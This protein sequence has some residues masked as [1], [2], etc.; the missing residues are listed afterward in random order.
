MAPDT[1]IT[2][3]ADAW[4]RQGRKSPLRAAVDS[5]PPM[6]DLLRQGRG[7]RPHL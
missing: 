5:C 6:S 1:S 4:S 2:L 7:G 3:A